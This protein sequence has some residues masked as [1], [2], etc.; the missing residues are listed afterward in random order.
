MLQFDD[1][2]H[3]HVG[4]YEDGYDLEGIFL[5]VTQEPIWC[6][7]FNHNTYNLTLHHPE[8]YPKSDDFGHLVGLYAQEEMNSQTGATH[9]KT[10][11]KIEGLIR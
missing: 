8:R 7:F 3:L 5:K 6:L 11:L 2:I 9:L 10:F 4:Y 1:S